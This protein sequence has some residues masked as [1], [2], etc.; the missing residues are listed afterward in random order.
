MSPIIKPIF[1]T[2]GGG[3]G[4]SAFTYAQTTKPGSPS[5]GET[6]FNP[7]TGLILV[8]DGNT[9]LP[10][11]EYSPRT[12]DLDGGT[13]QV[14]GSV[15]NSTVNGLV[16]RFSYA[17]TATGNG[18]LICNSAGVRNYMP[19]GDTLLAVGSILRLQ[20][21]FYW[22]NTGII[23]C[24]FSANSPAAN[25][26]LTTRGFGFKINATTGEIFAQHHD[27]STLTT[28][29]ALAT[30]LTP[31]TDEFDFYEVILDN[32][33]AGGNDTV[34]LYRNFSYLG[35]VSGTAITQGLLP[36]VTLAIEADGTSIGQSQLFDL[37]Y[38]QLQRLL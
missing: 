12:I 19:F 20:I 22:R 21:V 15:S 11:F 6:W 24:Y 35:S 32:T 8:S 26:D 13:A 31:G 7:D 1:G 3:G 38:L 4:T 36:L 33:N 16:S 5:S 34:H 17:D 23:R 27:G 10:G 30:V 2:G 18:K 25:S 28:S 29:S 14:S 9:W 37:H